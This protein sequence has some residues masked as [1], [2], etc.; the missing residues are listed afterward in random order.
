MAGDVTRARTALAKTVVGA[1][2]QRFDLPVKG[3][4]ELSLT[5]RPAR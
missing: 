5:L 3:S 1:W 2:D 4:R